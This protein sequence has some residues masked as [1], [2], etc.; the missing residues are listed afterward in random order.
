M[1]NIRQA[2]VA[3][4]FYPANPDQLN[5]MLKHYLDGASKSE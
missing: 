4:S 2:A 3:G 1:I 5:L